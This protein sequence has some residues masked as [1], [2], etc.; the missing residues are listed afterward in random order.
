MMNN[1]KPV[2]KPKQFTYEEA[3]KSAKED[4]NVVRKD[5]ENENLYSRKSKRFKKL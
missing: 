3:F 5:V 2:I 4:S 1:K